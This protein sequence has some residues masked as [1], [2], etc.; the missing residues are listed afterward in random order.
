LPAKPDGGLHD[1]DPTLAA[2]D[3]QQCTARPTGRSW[4]GRRRSLREVRGGTREQT[5]HRKLAEGA[6]AANHEQLIVNATVAFPAL[7]DDTRILD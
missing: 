4:K 1:L 3:N 6:A 2:T 7:T 5:K